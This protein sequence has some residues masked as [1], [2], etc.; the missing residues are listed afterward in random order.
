MKYN[1][2]LWR[3]WV[4]M[5]SIIPFKHTGRGDRVYREV[6]IK[7]DYSISDGTNKDCVNIEVI[8]HEGDRR[9][10]NIL[11]GKE[12]EQNVIVYLD[13]LLDVL[14]ELFPDFNISYTATEAMT[15]TLQ[16]NTDSIEKS[17]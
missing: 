14:K 8:W 12:R 9:D 2:R 11:S 17:E 16:L 15:P 13:V 3:P 10:A 5:K 7:R 4:E 6:E 1:N